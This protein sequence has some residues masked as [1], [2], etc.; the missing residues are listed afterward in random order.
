MWFLIFCNYCSNLRLIFC[1]GKMDLK[2]VNCLCS[3]CCK[4][5]LIV[6]KKVILL[7]YFYGKFYCWV[8]SLRF[9]LVIYMIY[10]MNKIILCLVCCISIKIVVC[11]LLKVVVLLIVVIVFVVIFFMKIIKVVKVFGNKVLI[12]L[13]KI[14]SLMKWFFLVVIF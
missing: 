12:I 4:V 8:L 3:G 1:Y 6:C 9:I 7:I 13:C 14:Y 2:C 5:L 10:W 11:W